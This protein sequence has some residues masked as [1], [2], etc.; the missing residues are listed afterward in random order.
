M[1]SVDSLWMYSDDHSKV[2]SVDQKELSTCYCCCP[3]PATLY[4]HIVPRFDQSACENV[5]F[6]TDGGTV[7]GGYSVDENTQN[8]CIDWE[9]DTQGE[10]NEMGCWDG[11]VQ[12]VFGVNVRLRCE[13][14]NRLRLDIC[15][16]QT[17]TRTRTS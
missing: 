1:A 8:N 10:A 13:E 11:A 5:D 4:L 14:T 9:S 17:A 7:G 12:Q 2:L 3:L 6:G 15:W 16:G